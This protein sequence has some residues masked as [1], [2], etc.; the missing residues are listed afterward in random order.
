MEYYLLVFAG[1]A[2]LLRRGM[3]VVFH[4]NGFSSSVELLEE[5]FGLMKAA[6]AA[7]LRCFGALDCLMCIY[8]V[9][10]FECLSP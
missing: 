3:E 7:L 2:V 9:V 8:I 10:D 1:A 6:T 5:I 4:V